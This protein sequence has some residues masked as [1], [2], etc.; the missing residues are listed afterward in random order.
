VDGDGEDIGAFVEDVL[1]A[2]AVVVI[3]VE[4]RDA[5]LGRKQVGSD[6][7]VVEVAEASERAVLGVM[8]GG[9]DE[10]VRETAPFE[11]LLSGGEGAVD[12]G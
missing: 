4:D 11:E 8:S 12:G 10:C 2:V 6:G 1:L 3:D 5:A 7:G 9:T